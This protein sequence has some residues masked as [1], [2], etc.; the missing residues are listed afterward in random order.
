MA[1]SSQISSAHQPQNFALRM[2]SFLEDVVSDLHDKYGEQ[3]SELCLVLPSRRAGLFLKTFIQQKYQKTLWAPTIITIEEFINTLSDYEQPDNI[4]LLFE[5]YNAYREVEGEEVAETF[6]SFCKWGNVLLN[7]FNEVDQYLVDASKLY[8]DL[9]NIKDIE[10]W[11]FLAEELSGQQENYRSFWDKMG[12]YYA[13]FHKRL[14]IK[15]QASPGFMYRHVA[16][17]IER[18]HHKIDALKICF[19]GF[20]AMSISEQ[21][22]IKYLLDKERAVAYWD[23]DSYYVNNKNHEAGHF[24]RH[25]RKNWREH[26]IPTINFLS[27]Q[28]KNV[29]IIGVPKSVGQAKVAGDIVSKM[30]PTSNFKSTAIVL[31]DEQLLLPMLHSVPDNVKDINVTMGYALSYTPMHSLFETIFAMHDNAMK[32]QRGQRRYQFYHNDVLKLLHHPYIRRA[33]IVKDVGNVAD[34]VTHYILD[35][36]KI[37]VDFEMLEGALDDELKPLLA[38]IKFLFTPLKSIPEHLLE[39]LITLIETLRTAA[40]NN[41]FFRDKLELEYLFHYS[42]IIKRLQALFGSY[43]FVS[44]IRSFKTIFNQVAGAHQ[45]TFFGEPLRGMQLMGMLETRTLDFDKVIVLS[46]N[47]DTL[48]K[49]RMDNS[50]I[51]YDLKRYYRLPTYAEK[52]AIY[53]YHFYRLLQRAKDITLIYNT[54]NDDFGSGE[55]SRFIAQLLHELPKANPNVTITEQVVVTPIDMPEV[56]PFTVPKDKFVIDRLDGLVE[57]G[58]SPTALSVYINCPLDFYYRYLLG[59]RESNEVEE[60]VEAN[61]LGTF[62][63]KALQNLYTP[64]VGKVVKPSDLRVMLEEVEAEVNRQFEEVFT[65]DEFSYGKNYLILKV[66][67]NFITR[68]LT[69]EIEELE[70]GEKS[71]EF[72]TIKMLE[73]DL[74]IDLDIPI[75]GRMQKVSIRGE[76]D[77]I[78]TFGGVTRII[79]YKTGMAEGKNLKVKF[80]EVI[81]QEEKYSKGFQV[82]MYALMYKKLFPQDSQPLRSGIISFRN[83]K[84]KL[85]NVNINLDEE[86]TEDLLA[87]FELQLANLIQ[88]IY[89]PEIPFEHNPDSKWCRF[90]DA[91]H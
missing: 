34:K 1:S 3:V 67:V 91:D 78:D 25:Y 12:Q 77:R 5:L 14:K 58:L 55:K 11:S 17:D 60:T 45:L 33:L 16:D 40:L 24:I 15:E 64:F 56:V 62:I 83:L 51:P 89:D 47:E 76:A 37:F 80:L 54:E 19:I 38:P 32:M 23:A 69:L 39:Q 81:T 86:L 20:N 82:L 49:S 52:D 8:S 9:V 43:P 21:Q 90:C 42:K 2:P 22:I 59:L 46:V 27:E 74:R 73:Y 57:D 65:P 72:L 63:H 50:F 70:A 71:N 6:D 4:T 28:E 10:E 75:K 68:F 26:P 79:D 18:L 44:E 36:N 61:T 87:D 7:D 53:A 30:E 41:P 29:T 31:A 35:K 48:P 66:A 84:A 88:D 85:M 13:A